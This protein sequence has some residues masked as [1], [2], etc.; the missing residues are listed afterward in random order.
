M[1]MISNVETI[2][3][4]GTYH[5]QFLELGT[6]ATEAQSGT[7]TGQL[8]FDWMDAT[9]GSSLNIT[10]PNDSIDFGVAAVPE[11][12]SLALALLGGLLAFQRRRL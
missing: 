11:P 2:T 5:F 7:W 8:S 1:Q 10:I 12:S 3:M 4:P 6:V 9:P